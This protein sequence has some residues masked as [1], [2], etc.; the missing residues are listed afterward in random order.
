MIFNKNLI[1]KINK[2]NFWIFDLDNTIYRS[3]LNLFPQVQKRIGV[4]VSNYLKV[5]IT[6]AK[7]IQKK[8]FLKYK[9]TLRGLMIEHKM[10][11]ND[12][13]DFVHDIDYSV[14]KHDSELNGILNKLP[15]KKYIYTNG[16]TNH[17]KNVLENMNISNQFS[18][19]FDIKDSNFEPKPHMDS[20]KSFINKFSINTENALMAEDMPINLAPPSKLGIKT[21][22][23]ETGYNWNKDKNTEFI[24]FYTNDLKDWLKN[25]IENKFEK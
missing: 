12:F 7:N 20:M 14:L 6:E 2:I 9:S 19:I 5:N 22:L 21:L 8:F 17:A 18:G 15:G 10:I 13:L 3:D 25:I 4:F 1:N 23:V 16:S 24:D 11:P